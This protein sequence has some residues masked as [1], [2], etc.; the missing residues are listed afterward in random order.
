MPTSQLASLSLCGHLAESWG[1]IL[2]NGLS[3]LQR[4]GGGHASPPAA[5]LE[6]SYPKRVAQKVG[7]G[8]QHLSVASAAVNT[9]QLVQL[10]VHPVQA[11]VQQILGRKRAGGSGREPGM[12]AWLSAPLCPPRPA[13]ISRPG[14]RRRLT[15]GTHQET[16]TD[17]K[18]GCR[19][20]THGA[21]G[22]GQHPGLQQPPLPPQGRQG[23]PRVI[24]L[25][26]SILSATSVCR[27]APLSP[28]FSILAW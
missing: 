20:E 5:H 25:G 6:H 22:G 27:S 13:H 18:R 3:R 21:P 23:S 8:N 16:G 12:A 28:D 15:R 4:P 10:G 7:G 14:L 1:I 11:L 9:G 26:H 24:P 19:N 17:T 2:L